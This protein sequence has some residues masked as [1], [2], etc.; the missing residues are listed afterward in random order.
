MDQA[1][2]SARKGP[3]QVTF[4]IDGVEYTVEERRQTAAALLALAGL[5]PAD[6]DVAKV[7]GQGQVEQRLRDGDT[8]QLTP[9]AAFVSIFTGPTPVA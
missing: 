1:V 2:S 5:D 4:T 6:H 9:G 7:V 3:P 8:V